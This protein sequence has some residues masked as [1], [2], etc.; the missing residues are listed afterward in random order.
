[1][2]SLGPLAFASPWILTALIGL[3]AIWWLLRVMP[4]APKRIRFPAIRLLLDLKK[5]EETPAHTPWWLL[6]LRLLI[7]ALAIL[8]LADPV[9]NPSERFGNN[10]VL[11]LALDDGW[12]AATNWQRRQNTLSSLLEQAKRDEKPVALITLAPTSL[13]LNTKPEFILLSADEAKGLLQALEPKPWVSNRALALPQITAIIESLEEKGLSADVV[14]LSDG[15]DYGDAFDFASALKGIGPVTA[16]TDTPEQLAWA[17]APP[18]S[19]A[20]GFAARILRPDGA[21]AAIGKLNVVGANDRLL[22]HAEFR[23]GTGDRETTTQIR[24]PLELRNEA[25]RIDIESRTSAGAV[26]LLDERWRR[27]LIGLV[28]SGN[29]ANAQPL[30]SDIYYLERAVSPFAEVRKG[31]IKELLKQD[32]S[33]LILADVGQIV[34]ADR[35]SVRD[36]VDRGGVLIRFAGP[37]MTGQS[38][39]LVPVL[40]RQGG[41]TLGGALSWEE[42]QRLNTFEESSPFFG[43]AIPQDVTITRQVLAQPSIDLPLRTW[44]R[45]EDG[46]PLVTSAPSEKGRIVLFHVTASPEWSSLPLSGLYVEMLQRIVGLSSGVTRAEDGERGSAIITAAS[47]QPVV[48]LNGFGVLTEPPV[49]ALPI[50]AQNL[51]SIQPEPSHPPGLYAAD[52]ATFALN[53]ISDD[54]ELERLKKLPAGI[55]LGDF[56]EQAAQPLKPL[57]LSTA[58]LLILADAF[59]ALK[60]AGRFLAARQRVFMTS[61]NAAQHSTFVC[62]VFALFSSGITSSFAQEAAADDFALRATLK[63]PLAYVLTGDPAVDEMSYYGLF[64]LNRILRERTAMEPA[65]PMGINIEHEE[66]VFFPF[67]YW[68]VIDSQTDLSP[69]A[70]AKVDAYMKNGGT[71]LFDTQDHQSSI[72]SV[73]SMQ[74]GNVR[75]R[76]LLAKLDIPPLEPVPDDHVLTKAFYL[77]QDF[78]GRWSGERVWVEAQQQSE[79]IASRGGNDGVSAIIIGSNDYAAAWAEDEYGRRLAAVVPG[80]RRQRELALRFGVNLVMYTLTGNYKAD[81]VHVPALLE[82]LGQ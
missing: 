21:D 22:G 69:A 54:F 39:E 32:V 75:L 36:W 30:L 78:P 47:Y 5:Q 66:L 37:R 79:N 20:G 46:T 13:S 52:R 64:G 80:G 31:T 1:M 50:S 61:S 57:L 70:L 48:T 59:A 60:L 67:L 12:P 10:D 56:T 55:V 15:I 25:R 26:T 41:R 27:R 81:Q 3:P 73:R 65:D 77:L 71:I 9:L 35:S 7:A 62:I 58:L 24:M 63:T 8:A 49:T 76:E 19:M 82:R 33:I 11:V 17:L 38:D 44:A 2:L 53:P 34:G 14:W 16:M 6:L 23:F 43:L 40:L 28:T 45:L 68:P 29:A 42:P 74:T 4:P 51:A 72:R 18:E